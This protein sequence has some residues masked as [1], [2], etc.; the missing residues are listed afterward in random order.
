M[1][2]RFGLFAVLAAMLVGCGTGSNGE[3]YPSAT[4][5]VTATA[6]PSPTSSVTPLPATPSVTPLPATPS[7]A[8]V[9]EPSRERLV[10]C[11]ASKR[12]FT[13]LNAG[14]Y[15]W[16]PKKG[17]VTPLP[18]AAALTALRAARDAAQ[19]GAAAAP[20]LEAMAEYWLFTRNVYIA[21]VAGDRE[22][23]R[24]AMAAH[25]MFVR[26]GESYETFEARIAPVKALNDLCAQVGVDIDDF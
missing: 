20:E 17:T 6:T 5:T 8:A 15:I 12:A 11:K 10:A 23:A 13:A 18:D 22:I 26:D 24:R 19:A 2:R 16:D 7:Q 1:V 3:A 21:A 14:P 4:V 25:P 9:A